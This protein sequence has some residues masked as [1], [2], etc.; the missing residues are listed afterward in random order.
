MSQAM[1]KAKEFAATAAANGFGW[2]VRGSVVTI[3]KTFSPGDKQAFVE[4]DMMAGSVLDKAPLKGGSVWGT[5]GGSV[6]GHVALRD[7]VFV[8]NKSGE[9]TR[10]INALKQLQGLGNI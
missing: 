7:G 2:A 10:F 4:A 8:L 9:G 6:G 5:D 1:T 3:T